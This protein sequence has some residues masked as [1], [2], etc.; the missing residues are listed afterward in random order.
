[1]INPK[2]I[3]FIFILIP[4]IVFT[5]SLSELESEVLYSHVYDR[6]HKHFDKAHFE[7]VE[8]TRFDLT[9]GEIS[10]EDIDG[11]EKTLYM[12]EK[13]V[14]N[15]LQN[16]TKESPKSIINV[17]SVVSMA[18]EIMNNKRIALD[19]TLPK[20]AKNKNKSGK[21]VK[22]TGVLEGIEGKNII[23][24]GR[25]V[26]LAEGVVITCSSKSKCDCKC[27]G[28]SKEEKGKMEY[29]IDEELITIAPI[30]EIQGQLQENGVML[31]ENFE[32]K[33]NIV[34]KWDINYLIKLDE[35]VD[36]NMVF[37]PKNN[38]TRLSF[39]G[40]M[41]IAESS[42]QI[43]ENSDAQ[44]YI[45]SIGEKLIPNWYKSMSKA[46]QKEIS[47]YLLDSTS[48]DAFSHG[49]GKIFITTGL[50]KMIN[51]EHQLAFVLAHEI[52][53]ITHKH[54]V[55]LFEKSETLRKI[56]NVI[57]SSAKI[58]S[59][60]TDNQK[61]KEVIQS[62][63][64]IIEAL[65]PIYFSSIFPYKKELQAD[66][67][68]L[69]YMKNGG[70]DLNEVPKLWIAIKNKLSEKSFVEA[71][72]D[73]ALQTVTNCQSF[74]KM[75]TEKK[76]NSHDIINTVKTF[77]INLYTDS[78]YLSQIKVN[79]RAMVSSEIINSEYSNY[80][81]FSSTTLSNINQIKR[82]IK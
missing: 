31:A 4:V 3:V 55:E 64:D 47:F 27:P 39:K 17:G 49:D 11:R 69:Y 20:I 44:V 22:L 81:P 30:A 33:E 62:S 48:P 61:T 46:K 58:A 23:V 28:L 37:S 50:L 77:A 56:M 29:I 73:A 57:T 80:K 60:L 59:A 5:Q 66:R 82:G 51:N 14:F 15:N 53:H 70:Y 36:E 71:F 78:P 52:A 1:M 35:T 18:Y 75:K 21:T 76:W 13:T 40:N 6:D 26:Q 74:I 9:N 2:N 43:F 24:G 19:I 79:K 8:V 63:M 41:K 72:T 25:R 65:K 38:F 32:I 7:T 34:T 10:V 68:G 45:N 42:Y 12:N 54:S 16:K 67:V